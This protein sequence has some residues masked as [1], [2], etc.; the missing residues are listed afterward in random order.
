MKTLLIGMIL[1]SA[2]VGCA[3]TPTAPR[4]PKT[5]GP[6]GAVAKVEPAPAAPGEPEPGAARGGAWIGAA[7]ASDFVLAGTRDTFMGIWVDVP[8]AAKRAHAPMA[9]AL[10]ID[11]SGSMAGAKIDNA[12]SAA[13]TLVQGLADG[14]IVAIDTFSDDARERVPATVVNATTRARLLGAIA[15]LSPSGGTNMFDGLRLGET[16]VLSAPATH[17]IRRVVMIS[18][19]LATVGAT[20]PELLG[21]LAA[22]GADHGV[23]V[24][25]IGVG[26]DYDENTLNALAVRSSG[27]LYH[28][29]E[30]REMASIL[31]REIKLLDSTMAT[32]AFV[33]IVPAPGVQVLGADG[34]RA[35]WANGALRVPMGTMFGGQHR[36]LLVRVRVTADGDGSRPLAS[37][38][39]HFRDPSDGN[40]DRVQEVVARHE[41]THDAAVVE[42]HANARTR[43]I[44]AV[45]EGAQVAVRAAQQVNQDQF[46][47]ADKDLAAAEARIRTS[48]QQVKDKNEQQRI[49]ATA[50]RMATARKSAQAAAAAPAAAKPAAKRAGALDVNSAGMSAAGF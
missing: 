20:S 19:G 4:Q 16:T 46:E 28:L 35:D 45:Q 22:R 40:I 12:R 24:T 32:D 17:P 1:A 48:A 38:R 37:V 31:D 33:E 27:R 2:A 3:A 25:S 23:Q 11:T 5:S 50:D 7:G 18:D 14:D 42:Q 39:L 44:A 47:A 10:V 43:A 15:E 34:V 9:L 21:A 30:P 6:E 26:L 41:V 49:L 36:E 8:A 29:A 13:R